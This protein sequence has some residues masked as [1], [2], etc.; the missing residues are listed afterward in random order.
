MFTI[1]V[2]I[3]QRW[4]IDDFIHVH[5]LYNTTAQCTYIHGGQNCGKTVC[6]MMLQRLYPDTDIVYTYT[7]VIFTLIN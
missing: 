4:Y 2:M 5:T 6:I 1:Y 7:L 3:L